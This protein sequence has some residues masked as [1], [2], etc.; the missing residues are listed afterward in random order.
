[1]FDSFPLHALIENGYKNIIGVKL[2]G[3]GIE[4]PLRIPKDVSVTIIEPVVSI[5]KSLAFDAERAKYLMK[6]GY[7]DT[8]K[9]LYGLYGKK[10]YVKRTLSD[11]NALDWLLDRYERDDAP[12]K[13]LRTL[14]EE[15]IPGIAKRL[16]ER[17]GNYYEIMIA[18][19]EEEAEARKVEPFVI[20][21]DL[22]LMRAIAD[23]DIEKRKNE[24][25]AH[26]PAQPGTVAF[27]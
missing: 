17:T 10:Y 1:M 18:M 25:A 9:A 21:N 6:L 22:E 20:R 2:P 23:V 7:F 27:V 14:V 8:K 4:R 5:G 11:R 19:L 26:M 13:P 15:E 12:D 16:G 3:K 24:K